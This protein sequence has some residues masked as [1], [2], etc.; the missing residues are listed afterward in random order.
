MEREVEGEKAAGKNDLLDTEVGELFQAR[1]G[2]NEL[3][4]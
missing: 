1:L 2:T 4:C 3:D